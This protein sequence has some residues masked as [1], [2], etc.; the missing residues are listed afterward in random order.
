MLLSL[1]RVSHEME[2]YREVKEAYGRL[3]ILDPGLAKRF[4][5]LELTREES[6]RAA[7]ADR[8]MEVVL[9]EEE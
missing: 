9:W 3:K 1:A 7:G 4:A 5:Y 2:N 6:S 8:I